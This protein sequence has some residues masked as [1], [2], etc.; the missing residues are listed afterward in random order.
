[1]RPRRHT[2]PQGALRSA[3]S[4]ASG[5]WNRIP[6]ITNVRSGP[7]W[8]AAQQRYIVGAGSGSPDE[9]FLVRLEAARTMYRLEIEPG[10]A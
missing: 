5:D 8:Q 7:A 2:P 10:S 9:D 4:L 3:L 6:E 1:M